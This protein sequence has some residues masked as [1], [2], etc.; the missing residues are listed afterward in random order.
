MPNW[1]FNTITISHED[2]AMIQRLVKASEDDKVLT[3]FLP[4]PEGTDWY[5]WQ[6]ENWGTKWDIG[7]NDPYV[8]NE[9]KSLSSSFDSAW[10]P[11]ISAYEKLK[12]MGFVIEATYHEPGMCYAGIWSD[13]DDCQVDYDFSDP[14]WR[15]DM[16]DDIVDMLEEDYQAFLEYEAEEQ[17]NEA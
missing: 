3:E 16:P 4:C 11:P 10:S 14:N 1:C 7:F 6:V 13:G 2:P 5:D 17:A 12:E 9:G 8:F 15:D